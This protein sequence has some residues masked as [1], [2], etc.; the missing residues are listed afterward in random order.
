[1][2][3]SSSSSSTSYT[4]ATPASLTASAPHQLDAPAHERPRFD[5]A[6]RAF[7]TPPAVR[8]PPEPAGESG[9]AVHARNGESVKLEDVDEAPPPSYV[10]LL[11][12]DATK[13]SNHDN[14]D[15]SNN[16]D[17]DDVDDDEK[18]FVHLESATPM[19]PSVAPPPA[20]PAVAVAG[21]AVHEHTLFAWGDNARGQLASV[22]AVVQP[23]RPLLHLAGRAVACGEAFS[24]LVTE[25]GELFTWGCNKEGQLGR[26]IT[27]KVLA[28]GE[29]PYDRT[30]ISIRSTLPRNFRTARVREVA[31][32]AQHVAVVF[33]NGALFT[34]GAGGAGQLGHGDRRARSSFKQ[35]SAIETRVAVDVACGARHTLVVLNDG[36]LLAFGDNTRGQL[37]VGAPGTSC[38]VPALVQALWGVALIQVAAGE[39]HTLVLGA[40]R[41]V[42][43]FGDNSHGQ[44][45]VGREPQQTST[46]LAVPA[47]ASAVRR[48]ACGGNRS[49]AVVGRG[50][51]LQWGAGLK[52]NFAAGAPAEQ[53][54]VDVFEPYQVIIVG[55]HASVVNV[56]LGATHTVCVVRQR[57]AASA[58]DSDSDDNDADDADDA[59]ERESFHYYEH[60][61]HQFSAAPLADAPYMLQRADSDAAALSM[62]GSGVALADQHACYALACGARHALMLTSVFQ[63]KSG[64]AAGQYAPRMTRARVETLAAAARAAGGDSQ[65][66]APAVVA[67]T[68]YTARVFSSAIALNQSCLDEAGRL[69]MRDVRA[70]YMALMAAAP[71]LA[72]RTLLIA[73][74][75]LLEWLDRPAQQQ[76][77]V[78]PVQLRLLFILLESPALLHARHEH[79]SLLERLLMR[80]QRLPRPLFVAFCQRLAR[81]EPDFF[82]MPVHVTNRFISLVLTS[83]ARNM[84][85]LGLGGWMAQTLYAIND[86]HR[87]V[88]YTSF[89]NA[90][91]SA[92]QI[93]LESEVLQWRCG[94]D[95][96]CRYPFLLSAAVKSEVLQIEAHSSMTR[97]MQS[98]AMVSVFSGQQQSPYL[99]LAIRREFIVEDALA[100]IVR[101]PP[102]D[103]KKPLKVVFADEEAIDAGG[104]TKEFFHL[105]TQKLFDVKYGMFTHDEQTRTYWFDRNSVDQLGEYQL[106]GILLG[107]AIYN[108]VILNVPFPP[109]LYAKLRDQKPT[110][111]DLDSSFPALARNLNQLLKYEADDVEDVFGLDFRVTSEYFGALKHH[112]LVPNGGDVTVTKA[113]REQY[114]TLYVDYLLDTSVQAQFNAFKHGFELVVGGPALGMFRAEEIELLVCGNH[115]FDIADLKQH[116]TYDGGYTAETRVVRWFWEVMTTWPEAKQRQ[117]LTFVTGSD[118]VPIGGLRSM[119][120]VIYRKGGDSEL[121]CSAATCFNTLYLCDYSSKAKLARKLDQALEMGGTGFGLK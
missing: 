112:D 58:G 23:M 33:D 66:H 25:D 114:V 35:V 50:A 100:N 26:R 75:P 15:N 38:T 40:S 2:A 51:L 88:S 65:Q 48:I 5:A 113:N 57:A 77:G 80:I 117:M 86:A 103:L 10:A 7:R 96:V 118:R 119:K 39:S 70:V 64:R 116:T 41:D 106:I 47:L 62:P 91:I 111:A 56:A 54:D 60:V 79:V 95:S 84:G 87:I 109:V 11:D 14:D 44:L 49:A 21:G 92:G 31:C 34:C 20:A 9:N 105:I 81:H 82:V 55:D 27:T 72:V 61:V 67:L 42:Y 52:R 19:P 90:T 74:L 22:G 53:A 83:P 29:A 28:K 121:L 13:P 59:E 89:Y 63:P 73:L 107:L 115:D 97:Q 43:A 101:R 8:A 37:G 120:F 98:A 12:N 71:Q 18:D 102:G 4:T 16:H 69:N 108:G 110:L 85:A 68:S 94:A 24:A 1:M 32:G 78:F 30:P 93:N 104:V 3:S 99:I 76:L 46:P 6:R 45:G 17:D 36:S